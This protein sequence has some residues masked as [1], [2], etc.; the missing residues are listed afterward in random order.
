VFDDDDPRAQKL[1][2]RLV[3]VVRLLDALLRDVK[4]IF[5]GVATGTIELT[6]AQAQINADEVDRLIRDAKALQQDLAQVGVN[7]SA[8]SQPSGR[9]H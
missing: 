2:R 7:V 3:D 4:R 9:V 6:R 8:P 5:T 1:E